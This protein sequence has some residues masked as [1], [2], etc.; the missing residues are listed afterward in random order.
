MVSGR[1]RESPKCV[2]HSGLFVCNKM[3][4]LCANFLFGVDDVGGVFDAAPPECE[5][6]GGISGEEAPVFDAVHD[7]DAVALAVPGHFLVE[8]LCYFGAVEVVG[9]PQALLADRGIE[10]E[11]EHVAVSVGKVAAGR[12]PGV[13]VPEE[14]GSGFA[15][16]LYLANDILVAFDIGFV[17][18]T[19]VAAGYKERAAAFEWCVFWEE[20]GLDVEVLGANVVFGI[21]MQVGTFA[22]L[23]G[24]EMGS[25]MIVAR[26]WPH[27]AVD[28]GFDFGQAEDFANG[29]VWPDFAKG[30]AHGCAAFEFAC[31]HFT[32]SGF[33]EFARY[34]VVEAQKTDAC[35]LG[36]L[37]G[38]EQE[39]FIHL[40]SPV[41]RGQIQSRGSRFHIHGQLAVL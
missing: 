34:E 7:F 11:F 33:A 31:A 25:V 9:V 41:F 35:K 8:V 19:E 37:G 22:C 20:G 30:C 10:A 29:F 6:E 12:V 39:V 16:G 13:G 4:I 32:V 15:Y 38:C 27:K 40:R 36:H 18:A 1:E 2:R 17:H 23:C 3:G 26:V 24:G 14:Y 5:V 28:D 21:L